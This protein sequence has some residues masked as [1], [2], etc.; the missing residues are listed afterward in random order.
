M[1]FEEVLKK[2]KKKKKGIEFPE[3]HQLN[4]RTAGRSRGM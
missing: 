3:K 1:V 2:K 4:G